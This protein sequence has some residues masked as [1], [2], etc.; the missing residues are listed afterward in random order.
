MEIYECSGSDASSVNR[1]RIESS[2]IDHKGSIILRMDDCAVQVILPF[3]VTIGPSENHN[4]TTHIMTDPPPCLTVGRRQSRSHPCKGSGVTYTPATPAFKGQGSR[5]DCRQV[6]T[7]CK[8]P[9]GGPNVLR[10]ASV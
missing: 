6:P 3:R 8:I 2:K 9:L 5:P 4:L 10:Y 7:L 1:F